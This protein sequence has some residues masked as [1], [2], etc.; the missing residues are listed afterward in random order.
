MWQGCWFCGF[1]FC[2]MFIAPDD[3]QWP[4][5]LFYYTFPL[6]YSLRAMAYTE[7]ID[8]TYPACDDDAS[9]PCFGTDGSTILGNIGNIYQL[10]TNTDMYAQ[11]VACLLLI[12]LVCKLGYFAVLVSKS[13]RV[14]KFALAR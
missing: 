4:F 10:I 3:I 1:L 2:G 8:S 5:K 6:K 12:A 7:F 11:D 13:R 14:S 9:A